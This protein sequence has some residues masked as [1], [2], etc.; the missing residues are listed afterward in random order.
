MLGPLLYLLYTA[1]LGDLIRRHDMDFH[2]YADD[3]QLYTTFCCD[4][5]DDL[6]IT[7]FRIESCL[8]D[9]T[10]WMTTNKLKLNTDKTE[11]LI[12]YPRF[13]LP[14]RLPSIKIGTDVIEPTN[15]AR[16]IGVIFDNTV[17]MSFHI[18]NIV[19]AA[20]YHLRNIANI[21]KYINVTTAEALV[22]AFVNS[23]LD[24]CNSLL[25]GLS[26]YEMNKLQ[27]VQNAAARVIACL[28]KF[29]HISDTLKELHWLPVEQR[30]IFKINL[31]CF[32]ILNNLAPD[33]LVDLIHVYEPTRY[34]RSASDKWRLVI[35]P[36]NLKTYG[37]RAFPVIA[38][39]LWNDLP[40]DI[41]SID[42]VNKFKSKLKTFLFKRV[43]ELS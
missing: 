3:T 42:D 23:K 11:L 35:E 2:Q 9:I 39:I 26:K 17:T 8:V 21:R 20:F 19:K 32:K 25:Y 28:S 10:N 16:N 31:I 18:N 36:Y 6:T 14:P 24:F 12:L 29:D 4:D 38:P 1:P 33:Y 7:I 40:I 37:L 41:R 15:K 5:Q 22:H 34:L 13:R 30:I 27:G 43:Y